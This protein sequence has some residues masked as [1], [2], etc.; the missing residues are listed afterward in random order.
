MKKMLNK[1]IYSPLNHYLLQDLEKM[2]PLC[3]N[4]MIFLNNLGN[5]ISGF[6]YYIVLISVTSFWSE[7][8]ASPKSILV[9]SL[10]NNSF[11]IPA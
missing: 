1:Q 3:R 7:L 9:L 5:K 8:L 10:K 11:S 4:G 6:L 2:P